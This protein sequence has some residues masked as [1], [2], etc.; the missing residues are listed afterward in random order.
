MTLELKDR[1]EL[2]FR[3][4]GIGGSLSLLIVRPCYIP[5]LL[6]KQYFNIH[7]DANYSDQF[8]S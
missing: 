2:N 1:N 3:H 4:V 5:W 8:L 7:D 6:D